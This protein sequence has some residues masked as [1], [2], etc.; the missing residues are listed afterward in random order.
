MGHVPFYESLAD[1]APKIFLVLKPIVDGGREDF[2]GVSNFVDA[3]TTVSVVHG[4]GGRCE[5]LGALMCSASLRAAN[6]LLRSEF[7]N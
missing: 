2:G 7:P 4:Y 5:L 3:C 1:A 6:P